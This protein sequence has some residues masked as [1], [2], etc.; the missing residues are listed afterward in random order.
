M[1]YQVTV[2]R[3]PGFTESRETFSVR[4]DTDLEA[5]RCAETECRLSGMLSQ[6][7]N[8]VRLSGTVTIR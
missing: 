1:T 4:A 5:R 8:V 3:I 2:E 7:V 6:I